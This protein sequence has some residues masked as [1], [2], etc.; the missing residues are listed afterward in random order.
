VFLS[1]LIP[2]ARRI[3]APRN[4]K[5][6]FDERRTVFLYKAYHNRSGFCK[7]SSSGTGFMKNK[8]KD[9]SV[10]IVSHISITAHKKRIA[11]GNYCRTAA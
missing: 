2:H 8:E 3:K 10:K 9:K 5:I 7:A 4:M 1:L 6:G 11:R